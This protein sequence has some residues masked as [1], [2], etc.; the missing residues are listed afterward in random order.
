MLDRLVN[1][2]LLKQT[3]DGR[4][5][6]R[7]GFYQA[8]GAYGFRDQLQ[9][10]LAML[11]YKPEIVREHILTCARHQ[12]RDGDVLHW[13]HPPMTGVRT[14]ISDDMLFLP[15]V[16]A[17]YVLHTGDAEVLGCEEPYLKNIEIP[18]GL[19]DIYAEMDLSGENDTLKNHCMLAFRRACRRGQHGLLLMGSGDWNDGMNRVGSRGRGESIWLSMFFVVCARLFADMIEDGMDRAW[20][21]KSADELMESV[22]KYGWDGEWYLRA[23]DDDGEKLGSCECDECVIDLI[24]QSWSVLSGCPDGMAQSAMDAAWK[25]LYDSEHHM[26]RLLTPP[27]TG[28]EFDPGYIAAYPPGVRENGGQYTHAACWYLIAL[29]K[30]GDAVRAK[31]LLNALMPLNHA[32]TTED[33]EL[34]RTEPYVMAA[35][36]YGEYPYT[37]RGGWTWY[38]GAAGWYL[39]A[40]RYLLGY[41]RRGDRVRMHALEGIWEKPRI[42]VR[43]GNARY[44]LVSDATIECTTLDGVEVQDDYVTLTDDGGEH[45]CMFAVRKGNKQMQ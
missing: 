40:V 34:Y 39:C 14:H 16:T 36:I 18:E 11:P 17:H 2:F 10:M 24:A 25:Y 3:L 9:D 41:E 33:A 13:W 28:K 42:T 37:G 35:D 1:G 38:T 30:Q 26:L 4:I 19:E 15:F 43:F 29:A 45:I 32:L 7:T 31:E 23:Y 8:G 21:M 5:Q 12:F 6:G 22:Q 20:L 27:F 44:T